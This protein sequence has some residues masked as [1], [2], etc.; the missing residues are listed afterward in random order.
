MATTAFG[1]I[2]P[3]F[4]STVAQSVDVGSAADT[5]AYVWIGCFLGSQTPVSVTV[6][7]DTLSNSQA[8]YS[9]GTFNWRLYYGELTVTGTQTI[10]A[11]VSSNNDNCVMV[12]IIVP[13][14]DTSGALLSGYATE[15][16]FDTAFDSASI[17]SSTGDLV[18][19]LMILDSTGSF[20][21]SGTT[22]KLSGTAIGDTTSLFVLEAPGASSVVVEGDFAAT[23]FYRVATFNV[24]MAGGGAYTITSDQGTHSITGQDATLRFNRKTIAVQGSY[25]LTGQDA[26]LTYDAAGAY[27]ITADYGTYTITGSDAYRDITITMS[28]G[29]YGVTGQDSTLTLAGSGAYT[30]SADFGSYGIT[31]QTVELIPTFTNDYSMPANFGAYSLSG[32]SARLSYSNEVIPRDNRKLTI[33]LK[34][35]I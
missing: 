14:V 33:A 19:S 16:T 18:Y 7:T 26:T 27:T 4:T 32:R 22:T 10:T 20:T 34:I 17:T 5:V 23:E 6:G 2:Q 1:K 24:P 13:G 25:T 29:T 3:P 15:T 9:D 35:S 30:L 21:A 28:H 12:G 8:Q 11:T 31:G